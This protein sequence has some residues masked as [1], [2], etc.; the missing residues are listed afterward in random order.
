MIE[1][2]KGRGNFEAGPRRDAGSTKEGR[3]G[4]LSGGGAEGARFHRLTLQKQKE[5]CERTQ[6]SMTGRETCVIEREGD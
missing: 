6:K 4:C 3:V 2:R 1:Q 5:L